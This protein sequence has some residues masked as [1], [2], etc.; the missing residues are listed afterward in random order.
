MSLKGILFD[1][2]EAL[3]EVMKFMPEGVAEATDYEQWGKTFIGCL[4][5]DRITIA[6]HP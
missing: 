1:N 3:V 5:S 6:R 4:V 2:K